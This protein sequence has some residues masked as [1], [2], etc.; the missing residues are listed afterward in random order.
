MMLCQSIKEQDLYKRDWNDYYAQKKLDGTRCLLVKQNNQ[1]NL[2]SRDNNYYTDKFP[3][4]VN[5]V[6]G[7]PD[8]VL[9]GEL[10]FYSEEGK[11]IFLTSLATAETIKEYKVIPKL[12]VF[13]VLE[14]EG[15]NYKNT[16]L[17]KRKEALSCIFGNIE[18]KYIKLLEWFDKPIKLWELVKKENRE[19]IILKHKQ[20]LYTPNYRSKMWL[21]LKNFKE[22][23]LTFNDYELMPNSKGITLINKDGHRIACLGSQSLNVIKILESKG[24]IRC[25]I[26]YLQKTKD[27]KY[28]FPSYRGIWDLSGYNMIR[29]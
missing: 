12:M 17:L 1:I 20:S 3:E 18:N 26:Q 15:I 4:I 29:N 5:E 14:L 7:L 6:K 9:D 10:T 28:R 22:A 2:I 19:G 16:P 21:K 23:E 24:K 8:C 25:K 27:D 13:D 11:D